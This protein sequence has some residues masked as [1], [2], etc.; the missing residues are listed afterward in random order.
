MSTFPSAR[1]ALFAALVLLPAGGLFAQAKA[2]QSDLVPPARRTV[3]T[4]LAAR[5]VAQREVTKLP[6]STVNPF[7]PAS[8]DAL[9]PEEARL[10]AEAARRAKAVTPTAPRIT[11]DREL[12]MAIAA[13][14]K[15]TGMVTLGSDPIL[16][17]GSRK[18]KVGEPIS[19]SF[20]G[21]PIAVT[22]TAID[23]TSFT[24]RLNSEEFTRPIKSNNP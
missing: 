18:I 2:I 8:F 21:K 20:E 17:M 3:T 5:L 6:D 11:T 19:A 9:D 12:L 24:L 13:Q 1:R 7:N 22:V 23:R 4:E 10:A 16:L 14:L 15:P